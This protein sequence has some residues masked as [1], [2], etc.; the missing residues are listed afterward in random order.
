MNTITITISIKILAPT[1]LA[2]TPPASNLSETL[3]FIPGNTLRGILAKRHLEKH[4]QPDSSD[5]QSLF[6]TGETKFGFGLPKSAEFLPLSARS[7]KYDSGFY[8]DG[9][10]GVTDLLLVGQ[11]EQRCHCQA[12]TDYIKGFW[13][14]Q[15]KQKTEVLTR[16]I[17]RTAIDPLR[18]TAYTGKLY[19]QRVL[20]E[21]QCF[22]ARIES[23]NKGLNQLR[24]LLAK[25]FTARIGTGTSR[26]QGWAEVSMAQ[27]PPH[28][29]AYWGTAADRF[30]RY[31]QSRQQQNSQ[32]E[33]KQEKGYDIE[34]LDKAKLV[35]T[36]LSDGLFQDDYLRD[37]T[38][39]TLDHLKPLG[40]N[41][42]DWDAKPVRAFMDTRLISGFDGE[43]IKLPRQQRMAV[44]AGSVFMF[45]S[46]KP[47]NELT[48]PTGDGLAWIG[49][50]HREGYGYAALWHPF[51]IQ[52][53]LQPDVAK[54]PIQITINRITPAQESHLIEQAE[55]L[56]QEGFQK[57]SKAQMAAVT[58]QIRRGKNYS[59][60][61]QR[62]ICYLNKQLDKLKN[63]I[64]RGAA[65]SSWASPIKKKQS[66][67]ALGKLLIEWIK[68]ETYSFDINASEEQ[69]LKLLRMFWNRLHGFYRFEEQ[70]DSEMNIKRAG[71]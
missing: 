28:L 44:T 32:A 64:E 23:S 8:Q 5:F 49:E 30:K 7:C 6:V 31:E 47:L 26:G 29:A 35:V 60:A 3:L 51:H 59:D 33:S 65:P 24:N 13:Q 50:N 36:L 41:P 39:P 1:L 45:I 66:E 27:N 54:Q 40:I 25:P 71:E 46:Q 62:A 12:P 38:A 11:S 9:E 37:V 21:G 67:I 53:D 57:I 19:S 63:K 48:I 10:H 16:L 15:D 70:T 69:K 4:N 56:Y 18:G 34:H 68:N 42:E 43:P 14:P 61:Q 58:V 55:K 22:S 20:E 52:P 2:A 17:T